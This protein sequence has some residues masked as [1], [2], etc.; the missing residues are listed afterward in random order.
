M[1]DPALWKVES[2][3]AIHEMA[4]NEVLSAWKMAREAQVSGQTEVFACT[5]QVFSQVIEGPIL[6]HAQD[7]EEGL[8]KE[9][10]NIN[11][12]WKG[13]IRELVPEHTSMRQLSLE[14]ES[15]ISYLTSKNEEQNDLPPPL[16]GVKWEH[17]R[18]GIT[19]AIPF[20]TALRNEFF[21]E[22]SQPGFRIMGPDQPS[23]SESDRATR[24]QGEK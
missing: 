7:E 6:I 1:S 22:L 11:S 13:V 3:H 17:F 18:D 24:I 19:A 10:L 12:D 20:G 23:K 4:W 2:H 8:Y 5:G 21:R 14:L 9:W 16:R 15:A